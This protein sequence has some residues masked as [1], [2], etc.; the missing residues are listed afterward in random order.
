MEK[1]IF[2]KRERDDDEERETQQKTAFCIESSK[3][4][5]VLELKN[6]FTT[7]ERDLSRS[8]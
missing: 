3:K 2:A 1:K 8:R 5:T 6:V 4:F 7:R